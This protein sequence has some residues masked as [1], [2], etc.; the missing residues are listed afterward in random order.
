MTED[1]HHIKQQFINLNSG[2]DNHDLNLRYL[3]ILDNKMSRLLVLGIS[4]PI[5]DIAQ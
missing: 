5:N 2:V 1:V 3:D 4:I